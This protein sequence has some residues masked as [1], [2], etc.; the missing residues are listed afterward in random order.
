MLCG[1]L[2]SLHAAHYIKG[3]N[4]LAVKMLGATIFYSLKTKK[5]KTKKHGSLL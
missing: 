4:A 1:A 2:R 3:V 5:L